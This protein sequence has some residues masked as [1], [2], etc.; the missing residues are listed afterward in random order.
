[1]SSSHS[2]QKRQ[3]LFGWLKRIGEEKD[4]LTISFEPLACA[5]VNEPLEMFFFFR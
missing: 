2:S 1:M 5:V 4:A 3:G